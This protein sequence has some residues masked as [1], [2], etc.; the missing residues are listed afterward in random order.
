M[1][2]DL[3]FLFPLPCYVLSII[4]QQMGFFMADIIFKQSGD[5][6]AGNHENLSDACLDLAHLARQ[7]MGD[8]RLEQEILALFLLQCESCEKTL[9]LPSVTAKRIEIAHQMKGCAKAVGA[10]DIAQTA[11]L[12]EKNPGKAELVS[13]LCDQIHLIK[14]YLNFLTVPREINENLH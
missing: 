12:L 14:E 5:Q 8:A 7:T 2:G 10:W 9:S 6:C 1:S 13:K 4:D 3:N 11:G